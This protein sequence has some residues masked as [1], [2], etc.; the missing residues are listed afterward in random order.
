MDPALVDLLT[1]GGAIGVLAYLVFAL[2]KRWLVPWETYQEKS[3][4]AKY[5]R[6]AFMKM[7]DLGEKTVTI[8]EERVL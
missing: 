1:R 5:W 7:A 6:D 8:V 3:L 2:Q 4:E